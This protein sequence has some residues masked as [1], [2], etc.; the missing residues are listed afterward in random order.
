MKSLFGRAPK[1]TPEHLKSHS[2]EPRGLDGA[3][4]E[5]LR[6]SGGHGREAERRRRR[7]G[8][9]GPR[10]QRGGAEAAAERRWSEAEGP[11]GEDGGGAEATQ[12]RGVAGADAPVGRRRPEA[13]ASASFSMVVSCQIRAEQSKE[14]RLSQGSE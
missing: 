12:G 8:G 9:G 1:G 3:R 11:H 4:K 2:L 10:R 5:W 6:P 13:T 7:Q 14:K